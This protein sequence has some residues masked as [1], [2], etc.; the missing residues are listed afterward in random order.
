[1]DGTT[2]INGQLNLTNPTTLNY[3]TSPNY[4]TNSLT[5]LGGLIYNGNGAN[6]AYINCQTN[7]SGCALTFNNSGTGGPAGTANVQLPYGSYILTLNA[8]SPPAGVGASI[9]IDTSSNYYNSIAVTNWNLGNPLLTIGSGISYDQ[10]VGSSLTTFLQINS[11][12]L[13]TY[14]YYVSTANAIFYIQ[15]NVIRVG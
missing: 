11:A 14:V 9:W 10:Y 13:N 4:N 7:P 15:Y 8:V 3:T 12:S 5:Q 6:M 2:I 1:M